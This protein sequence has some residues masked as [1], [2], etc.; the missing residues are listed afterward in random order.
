LGFSLDF[1]HA[2]DETEAVRAKSHGPQASSSCVWA[3]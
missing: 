2:N 3:V 1:S